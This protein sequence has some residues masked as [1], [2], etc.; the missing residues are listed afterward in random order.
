MFNRGGKQQE[1]P[2]SVEIVLEDGRELQGKLL[3]PP[4]RTLAEMLNGGASFIEFAPINGERMFIAKS[5]LHAVKPTNVPDTPD[6]WAGPTE[7]GSFDPFAVLGVK[8]DASREEVREAYFNLAKV[9]HPDRYAT[10]ELPAEVREYLS[11]MARRINAAYDAWQSSQKRQ[12]VKREPV[13][14]KAGQ[15]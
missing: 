11:V 8:V 7:G 3:I 13:F 4:G 5:A 12:A 6:L 15:G 2:V 9:Y 1:G 14:T 10:A